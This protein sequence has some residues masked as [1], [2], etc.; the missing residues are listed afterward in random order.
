VFLV[1]RRATD[2][3]FAMKV[4]KKATL[5]I[6]TK[7]VEHTKNERSILSQVAHNFIVKLHYAFQTPDKLFL[8]LQYAPGGNLFRH[9]SIQRMFHED[10]AAF[11]IGEL[12][13]AID[14]LHSLGIIYRDLKPEN[15]LLDAEGH[16]LL[17]DFGLSKVALETRTICG[18]LEYTAPE[19]FDEAN[20]YG[21]AV[22]Y[23]SLGAML[24]DMIT[25][26]PP[27]TGNNRKKVMEGILKK[28]PTF[29]PY[30]TSHATDLIK[31]L[32]TKNPVLR[33]GA[34]S[35]TGA[36]E[37]MN[38]RY[39][40]KINWKNLAARKLEPPIR[41]DVSNSLDTRNFHEC[42]TGMPLESPPAHLLSKDGPSAGGAGK[43]RKNKKKGVEVGTG[44]LSGEVP[45][46]GV[47]FEDRLDGM[48][49]GDEAETDAIEIP[50][51]LPSQNDA[52]GHHFH[53]FSYVREQELFDFL[54]GE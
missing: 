41:P 25:G 32:L 49:L 10:T 33:L 50:A 51:K 12:L 40:R 19:V 24:F 7:T 46:S 30:L 11:Y 22:D 8:I 53:G 3:I 1:R 5:V 18:T 23:W 17:T 38:H 21:R 34:N 52:H 35:E 15:V 44:K 16:V 28:K 6:H 13:L 45:V 39:F 54:N 29:P 20:H 4:L 31:K 14:H 48:H 47:S 37:M 9:L 26:S 36:T 27:F 43:K 2:E 42:Y